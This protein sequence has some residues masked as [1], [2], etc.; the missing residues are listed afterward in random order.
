MQ[1]QLNNIEKQVTDMHNALIGTPYGQKGII[2][3]VEEVEKYQSNDK[4]QKWTIG[5][6]GI[7]V[8]FLIKF[9]DK[10]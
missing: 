5:G 3:R 4:K 6:I 7:A 1:E 2:K 10:L 8:G 9:W